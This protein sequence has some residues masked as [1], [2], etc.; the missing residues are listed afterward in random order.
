MYHIRMFENRLNKT[1]KGIS[2]C[3]CNL[4]NEM[5][6]PILADTPELETNHSFSILM[7]IWIAS[8]GEAEIFLK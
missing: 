1:L 6:S 2:G 7:E 5:L 3:I 8:Y 4:K